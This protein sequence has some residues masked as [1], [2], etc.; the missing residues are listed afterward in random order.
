MAETT[1]SKVDAFL[2]SN[3]KLY[4]LYVPTRI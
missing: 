2:L 1:G 4:E 3:Q